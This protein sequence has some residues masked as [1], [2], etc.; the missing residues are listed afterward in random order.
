MHVLKKAFPDKKENEIFWRDLPQESPFRGK[1]QGEDFT[2]HVATQMA[3]QGVPCSKK[4]YR[5][6]SNPPEYISAAMDNQL[7]LASSASAASKDMQEIKLM[8]CGLTLYNR[9][10]FNG[11]MIKRQQFGKFFLSVL[12]PAKVPLTFLC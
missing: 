1:V 3:E 12:S 5:F 2:C 11:L 6:T 9:D 7:L 4:F 8:D 10:I